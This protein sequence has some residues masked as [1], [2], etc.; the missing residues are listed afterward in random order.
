MG[1]QLGCLQLVGK[2]WEAS[3]PEAGRVP[4]WMGG[5]PA[6]LPF[7]YTTVKTGVEMEKRRVG[8]EEKAGGR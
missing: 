5:H 6:S 4:Q 3:K 2:I 1:D 7:L 8:K